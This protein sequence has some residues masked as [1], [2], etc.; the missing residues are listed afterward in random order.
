MEETLYK[1]GKVAVSLGAALVSAEIACIGLNAA[2]DDLE[3]WG[4]SINNRLNPPPPPPKKFKLF[5]R[6]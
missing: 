2:I 3:I 4:V 6:K 5:R 1:I